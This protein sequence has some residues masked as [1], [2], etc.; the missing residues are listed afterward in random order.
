MIP[1]PRLI[2][3]SCG[4][5]FFVSLFSTTAI[6]YSKL[7]S[8]TLRKFVLLMWLLYDAIWKN[9][10]SFLKT[11]GKLFFYYNSVEI[12]SIREFWCFDLRAF[13]KEI[14]YEF[15]QD[16]CLTALLFVLLLSLTM[17]KIGVFKNLAIFAGKHLCWSR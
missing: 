7:F 14:A 2:A 5:A 16:I 10:R 4:R 9:I 12:C 8:L 13:Y 6:I 15:M 11:F 3:T 1:L 17:F